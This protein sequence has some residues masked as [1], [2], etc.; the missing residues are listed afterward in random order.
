MLDI[1][2]SLFLKILNEPENYQDYVA[3]KNDEFRGGVG[4]GNLLRTFFKLVNFAILDEDVPREL[5]ETVNQ[6]LNDRVNLRL[7]W[8]TK[9]DD[10][11]SIKRPIKNHKLSCKLV[12][13]SSS[14][15][16]YYISG[17]ISL[18]QNCGEGD[19]KLRRC[20]ICTKFY[21]PKKHEDRSKFCST[22]CRNTFHY[23]NNKG[24]TFACSVCKES[25][26]LEQF[27]GVAVRGEDKSFYITEYKNRDGICIPCADLFYPGWKDYIEKP[28]LPE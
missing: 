3:D 6:L 11:Y 1:P 9:E 4:H 28:V 15:E 19:F 5:E 2:P 10:F 20:H 26:K 21:I 14:R 25:K 8:W 27:T 22:K 17:I 7:S 16:D 23:Q 18:L 13:E 24:T 12:T